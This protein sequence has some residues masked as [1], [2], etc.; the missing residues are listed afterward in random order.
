M[1][2]ENTKE[3]IEWMKQNYLNH[4]LENPKNKEAFEKAKNEFKILKKQESINILNNK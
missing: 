4:I 3:N 1:G 2:S